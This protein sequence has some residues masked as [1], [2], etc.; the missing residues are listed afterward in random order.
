MRARFRNV[1]YKETKKKSVS[2]RQRKLVCMPLVRLTRLTE[3]YEYYLVEF[4]LVIS[5]LLLV[6]SQ[7]LIFKLANMLST[8]A[9]TLNVL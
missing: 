8:L 1:Q 7:G 4:S 6:S 2:A 9:I 5:N 3:L